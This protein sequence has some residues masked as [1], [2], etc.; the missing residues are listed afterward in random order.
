M[1]ARSERDLAAGL[2]FVVTGVGFAWASTAYD[3]GSS[4]NP[5]PAYFPFGLGVLLALLGAVVLFRAMSVET[6][7]G[8]R[9]GAIGWR[10]LGLVVGSIALF[11]LAL[12][13]LGLPLTVVLTVL[14]VSRASRESRLREALPLALALALF[15]SLL[16]VG[17]LKLNLPL[18]P[19]PLARWGSA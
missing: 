8:E 12:P 13:R 1:G 5:G 2:L 9:I 11:S 4:A 3:F 17:A 10:P 16:F 7:G 15:C 14:L 6:E 18:G 19:L